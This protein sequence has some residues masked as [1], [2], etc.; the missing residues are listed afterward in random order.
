MSDFPSG[1]PALV[2]ACETRLVNAWP[3][4]ESQLADGW[5]LRFAGGYSKRANSATPILAGATLDAALIDHI[6]AQYAAH[7]IQ[8]VFR[9]T[10][11]EA[12]HCDALL[13]ERG[14]ASFEPSYGMVAPL[15]DEHLPD[16]EVQIATVP[17]ETWVRE[18]AAAYGGDKA[19]PDLLMR[20]VS[21]IRQRA[22]FATVTLDERSVAWGLAVAERGFLGLFDIVV[23][24]ELRGLGLSRTVVN[25][26]LGWGRVQGCHTAYLQVREAN[27]VARDLY[28][29]LGF[30][31]AYRY[32]HRIA[33]GGT[34]TTS[35][36]P[37][38]TSARRKR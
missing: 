33:P 12:P 16:P 26:L 11:L 35:A 31:D 13:A 10:S 5:I 8:P 34:A 23:A 18:T 20:I 37:V 21:R 2:A 30:T 25:G 17:D 19:H 38:A 9:L 28:R 4:F 29:S 6:L 15:T 1:D 22:G 7:R 3:C 36:P 24:P 32:T 27:N 14:F